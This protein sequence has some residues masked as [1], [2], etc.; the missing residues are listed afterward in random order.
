M[1]QPKFMIG[2]KVF[3]S[4]WNRSE[5]QRPCP[6][7]L[8]KMEWDVVTPAQEKFKIPCNSCMHGYFCTGRESYWQWTPQI[9]LLTVGS[10][11][12]D[13]NDEKPISYM[14]SETGVGSGSVYYE[15]NVFENED[16]ALALAMLHCVDGERRD[17]EQEEKRLQLNRKK[18]RRKPEWWQRRIKELE[19]QLAQS[20]KTQSEKGA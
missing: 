13:T 11:R 5:K 6:D 1:I 15:T 18:S 16:D 4:S 10:I 3:V 9:K 19:T 8:G 14:M 12:V 7:C 2:Q 20:Q 17:R